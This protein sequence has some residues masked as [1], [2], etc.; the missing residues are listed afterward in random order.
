MGMI[1]VYVYV[2]F[3]LSGSYF[4]WSNSFL[5]GEFLWVCIVENF[6]YQLVSPI[7]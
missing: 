2:L 4:F 5:K 3:L 7:P 1:P 6:T